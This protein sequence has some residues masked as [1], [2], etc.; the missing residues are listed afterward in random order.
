MTTLHPKYR[1][2]IDGLRAIA[3]LS[4]VIFHAFPYTL[5]GGFIGV[6]VFFVISGFLISTIIFENLERGTFSFADF[7]ARRIKRIF[8]ALL[9]V[10]IA[11]FAFGWFA[12]LADE[13]MQLGKHMAAGAGMVSNLVLWGEAGYF[14]NSADTKPLLHLWSLGIEEQF[15]L[16]WPLTL[17]IAWKRK[18]NFLTITLIVFLVSFVLNM[19]GIRHSSVATF[20]SPQTRFWEMLSGSLLSWIAL[21]KKNIVAGMTPKLRNVLSIVGCLGLV[22]G[23][24]AINKTTPFP[25]KWAV[26]PVLAS[27]L[28]ILAGPQAWVNRRVLSHRFLVW[29]G[30]ISFPLYLWHWPILSFARIVESETLSRGTRISA[31]MI[32]IALAWITFKFVEGPIRFGKHGRLKVIVLATLMATVGLLGFYTFKNEGFTERSSVRNLVNNQNELIRTPYSDGDCFRHIGIAEPLFPYCKFTDASSTET[33]AVF[34]DSHAH[35]AFPGIADFLKA[36]GINTILLANSGCPPFLGVTTGLTQSAKNECHA[37]IQQL[38]ETVVKSKDISKVFIFTRGTT[39]NTG[40]EPVTGG[41]DLTNGN[42]IPI[43]AFAAGAQASIDEIS[44]S[45][46]QVFYV[47]EN[48]ELYHLVQACI[49][50]PFKSVI[51]DCGVQTSLVL[52]R[53]AAYLK[54][55]S[56]LKNVTIIN[57]L[58]AFCPGEKCIVFD[59]NGSLLYADSDHLSVAGSKFQVEKLLKPYLE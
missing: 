6:D 21:Y 19:K 35:V 32:S 17:W 23:F 46:K 11:S 8:P 1:P 52:E 45:G 28:I 15:Y 41:K 42:T 14:D 31:V 2:D 25:G 57:S 55:F 4:V 56:G 54:A 37:S 51:K 29:I 9:I 18:F 49:V 34:G 26:I 33:V 24:A 22:L 50:R 39:Y 53:Q 13:Y 5:S 59:E 20:Y 43:D 12:L 16:I 36:K 40:G 47:T 30:L 48:P 10:L 44:K 27:V 3:V 58:S 7:Y 38:V